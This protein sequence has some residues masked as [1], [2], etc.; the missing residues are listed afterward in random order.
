MEWG[1]RDF[2]LL[3][4]SSF[5]IDTIANQLTLA[6]EKCFKYFFKWKIRAN[7]DKTECI[8]FTRRRQE[9]K[10]FVLVEGE[11][12]PWASNIK[13]LGVLLDSKLKFT[14]HVNSQCN[15]AIGLMQKLFP[16]L[17]NKSKLSINNKKLIYYLYIRP[18]LCY[19]CPVWSYT[20]ASNYKKLQIT[21]NKFL[22]F[23]GSFPRRTPVMLIHESL[24]VPAMIP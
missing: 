15:K 16:L 22:R 21:Q 20:A 4:V 3:L 13:Y 23:V 19:A 14:I 12:L 8:L 1:G 24:D 17:N 18:L 5:R 11:E 6:L 9:V 7:K 10:N 2:F